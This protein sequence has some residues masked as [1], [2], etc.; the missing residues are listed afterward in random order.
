M[1]LKDTRKADTR[2]KLITQASIRLRRD[3]LNAVGLRALVAEAGLT[4]G[5]FYAHFPSKAK[6]AEAAIEEALT[7]TCNRLRSAVDAADSDQQLAAFVSAY[8]SELHWRSIDKGCMAA[9]LGP[10]ITRENAD[11]RAAFR[12]GISSIVS[13]LQ[14]LLPAGGDSSTRETRAA[15]IFAGMMGALQLARLYEDV[16]VAND[17]L[18][19][20]QSNALTAAAQ[21]WD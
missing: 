1:K 18:A 2:R 20:A 11:M 17:F 16:E 6:L 21:S 10:E 12:N 5:A 8:L 7:E 4:H 13:L 19:A 3:G 9:A 15:T 14:S